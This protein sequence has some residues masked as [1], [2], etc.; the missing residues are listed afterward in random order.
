MGAR[1]HV[2]DRTDQTPGFSDKLRSLRLAPSLQREPKSVT[3]HGPRPSSLAAPRLVSPLLP[4]PIVS[5]AK[6]AASVELDSGGD[7]LNPPICTTRA[8]PCPRLA[9]QGRA[10]QR[11]TTKR[12]IFFYFYKF[13]TLARPC[14]ALAG[15]YA[16]GSP[17][18][19]PRPQWR[20]GSPRSR[21]ALRFCSLAC[22]LNGRPPLLRL[23][24]R[25]HRAAGRITEAETGAIRC[26]TAGAHSRP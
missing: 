17:M 4:I 16:V 12:T 8:R 5:W 2:L 18:I 14:W 3:E 23:L 11:S 26:C 19:R 1:M 24:H 6:C 15:G 9:G 25:P 7:L 10:G 20:L 13:F 21:F 22:G